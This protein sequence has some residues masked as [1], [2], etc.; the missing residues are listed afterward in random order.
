MFHAARRHIKPANIVAVVALVFAM[1]GGAYAARRY[2]ITSTKQIKPS[3]LK[4]LRG[5]PGPAGERGPQGP[6]G[7]TG[8]A[9]KGEK[10]EKGER[11]EKGPQGPAGTN[12]QTGF[13][14]TLPSGETEKGEWTLV[15]EVPGS[16]FEGEVGN[17]VSFNI[18]L[19]SAPTV[20]YIR[21]GELTPAGCKGSVEE[22]G[23]EKG[24]LCIFANHEV[25]TEKEAPGVTPYPHIC[26]SS[27]GTACASDFTAPHEADPYGF[28]IATLAHEKGLVLVGGTWAVTAS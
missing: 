23:A 28:V 3:V 18:P 9:G 5:A 16:V 11:G 12:G 24:H 14:K 8:S 4:Q 25:N 27:I 7:S 22:P 20:V 1:T 6:A 17:S 15:G 21:E 13:T 2:L 19:A 26:A 10:G